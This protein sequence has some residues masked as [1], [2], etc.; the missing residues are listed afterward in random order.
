MKKCFQWMSSEKKK[1]LQIFSST[2]KDFNF[3]KRYTH[4]CSFP[5][6]ASMLSSQFSLTL[7]I[8]PRYLYF[9][10]FNILA[11]N[12]LLAKSHDSAGT[13]ECKQ[14]KVHY[15]HHHVVH[16]QIPL[17]EKIPTSTQM[18]GPKTLWTLPRPYY[19]TRHLLFTARK[20]DNQVYVRNTRKTSEPVP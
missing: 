14:T 2:E 4:F 9:F 6:T 16:S 17:D 3:H 8:V 11:V 5:S 12:K 13:H 19:N 18:P 10:S 1:K 15:G 20:A 7:K